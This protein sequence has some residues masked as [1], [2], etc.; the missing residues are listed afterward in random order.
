MN[1]SIYKIFQDCKTEE[2]IKSRFARYFKIIL[3][4]RHQIDLYT[5]QVIFEFK[6]NAN[7]KNIQ[8][9]AKII[10]QAL[11]YIRKLKYGNYAEVPSKYICGIEKE[12]AI[13]IE[14]TKL[15][16]YYQKSNRKNYDWDLSPSSPCQKLVTDLATDKIIQNC[17]VYDFT[18][19]QDEAQ[20]IEE[21]NNCLTTQHSLFDDKKEINEDNF[22][23]IFKYW[24]SLFGKYVE[25]GRKCSEYFITDIESGKSDIISN[26]RVLFTT[27]NG[28]ITKRLPIEDY[29]YFWSVYEKIDNPR[30]V[31]AIRQKMDRMS[32][33]ELRRFTGEFFTPIKFAKKAVEYLERTV[34][35]HW[36]KSGK[37]RLWDMAAGTGNLEFVLPAEALQYCYISTLLED[38]AKYCAK[39]YPEATVFQYDYLNDDVN[40]FGNELILDNLGVKRKMPQKLVDDLANPELKW[41]IFFNPPYATASNFERKNRKDKI[42]VSMTKIQKLMTK[43]ELGEVSRELYSQF[44]YRINL[45]FKNRQ[46]Y[47]GFFSKINYMNS[48][49]DQ[50]MRDEI[51]NYKFERGFLFSSQNFQGCKGKFPIGFVIWNMFNHKS[52]AEQK[53]YLDVFNSQIEKIAVKIISSI[54]RSKFLNKWIERQKNVKI[55]PPMNNALN[56]VTNNKDRRDR[57]AENF[58]ASLMCWNDFTH[59][60][61]T[62]LLSGPYASAGGMS[63]TPENFEQYMVIH[64]VHLIPKAT[65]LNDR[66]QFMQP[67]KELP[68][69]FITDAVIWSLFSNSNNTAAMSNVEYEGNIYQ[70]KNNFYPFMLDEVS[71]WSCSDPDIRQSIQLASIRSDDRFVAKWI[72]THTN[73]ISTSSAEVIRGG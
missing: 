63:V 50:K 61:Y 5:P 4:T 15:K 47:I 19:S 35:A 7:L 39:I 54:N 42:N 65:W 40:F 32:E 29:K 41:I 30:N 18:K 60:N 53:I 56:I 1:Q 67:T 44:L 72:K 9:R 6:L 62:A 59:Q 21:I 2:E 36:Y 37:F 31:I 25:N 22:Y 55:F 26:N 69:E 45:E 24:E 70:I 38:D 58:L 71:T 48:N 66:D 73:S 8:S 11:Y 13:L 20:F 10:A 28:E 46:A 14:T 16:N 27:N 33:I 68:Q 17:H 12:S 51:F 49:N 43:D 64:A 34:G 57:I 3:N 52:L 23:D